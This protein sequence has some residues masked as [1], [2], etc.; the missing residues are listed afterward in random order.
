MAVHGSDGGFVASGLFLK[1]Q[2]GENWW[3]LERTQENITIY[4]DLISQV[5]LP[6]ALKIRYTYHL[7]Y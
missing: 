2:S 7:D 1:I 5:G 6:V 3:L 4:G